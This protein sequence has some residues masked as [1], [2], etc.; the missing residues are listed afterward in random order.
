MN[1]P[2]SKKDII[3]SRLKEARRMAGLSQAQVAR[4][5]GLHRPSVSEIEAGHRRVIADELVQFA[6]LYEVSV[7]WLAGEGT[8]KLDIFDDKLQLAARE[9]RKLKP[10]DLDR[11]LALLGSLKEQET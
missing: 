7:S 11:L 1:A 5:L 8:E 2:D 6:E 3:A 9:L 4:L 10:A